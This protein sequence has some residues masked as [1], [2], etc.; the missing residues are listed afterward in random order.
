MHALANLR[1]QSKPKPAVRK[2]VFEG[3][4]AT[5]SAVGPQAPLR[6]V[7]PEDK[8][9]YPASALTDQNLRDDE[10]EKIL[11]HLEQRG[12]DDSNTD[13]GPGGAG[14]LP[15][16]GASKRAHIPGT[17]KLPGGI[18]YAVVSDEGPTPMPTPPARD[19]FSPDPVEG[20]DMGHYQP[21][22]PHLRG[23]AAPMR[24]AR[25]LPRRSGAPGS[26]SGDT[27][28]VEPPDAG[29]GEAMPMPRGG[30]SQNPLQGR[31]QAAVR[32]PN[33]RYLDS[34]SRLHTQ[35][36]VASRLKVV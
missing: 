5:R 27:D 20:Q 11:K 32:L 31:R 24:P 25:N 7:K 3:K 28:A 6:K 9:A 12:F 26:S 17:R 18:G 1:A 8:S 13:S 35:I 21:A 30:F 16:R 10:V 22:P 14:I 23:R 4:G 34:L 2:P 15:T 36:L 29:A 19:C 33:P